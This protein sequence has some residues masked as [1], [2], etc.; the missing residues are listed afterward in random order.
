MRNNNFKID[1]VGIGA[2]RCATTWIYECLREHPEVE[3]LPKDHDNAFFFK[4]GFDQETINEYRRYFKKRDTLK[5]DFHVYYLSTGEQI[6]NKVKNHNFQIKIIVCLRNPIDRAYSQYRHIKF[7]KNK[8][9]QSIKE[10]M[11]NIPEKIIEPGFYYKHLKRYFEN[12]PKENLL[13]LLYEQDIKKQP[14][15]TIKK[16]YE[17]LGVNQKFIPQVAKVKIN[18]I[19]FKETAIGRIIHKKITPNMEN[20]FIGRRIKQCNFFKKIYYSLTGN[21]SLKKEKKNFQREKED[22][23]NKELRSLYKEDI[24]NLEN[25]IKKD[26]SHWKY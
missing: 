8:N 9:W 10:A 21:L 7:A 18:P 1:F 16:I 22:E 20:L 6:I 24:E 11:Q 23:A 25:L 19:S 13:I 14:L 3:L 4:E 2:P 26:L 17:F 15:E 5:G 12:F